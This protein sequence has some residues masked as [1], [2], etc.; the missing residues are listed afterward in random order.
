MRSLVF[1]IPGRLETPTGGYVY[2]RRMI[3]GLRGQGWTVD[4]QTLDASFPHPTPAALAHAARTLAAVARGTRVLV[5]G[6]ACSAMP[7]L[8][9]HE[10]A[11]LRIAA[12]VHLP[13]AADLTRDAETSARLAA[14]EKRALRAAA[15]VI[16]TGSTTRALIENYQIAPERMVVVE[17][18]TVRRTVA[19]RL[20]GSRV[21][22]LCVATLHPGKGHEIL[23]D[24]LAPL[25]H[26]DWQLVCA[27]SLTRHPATAD[28][29]RAAIARLGLDR[30]VSL[31]GEL[32]EP[33]LRRCYDSADVFV[34]AT[35]QETYG[36]AVAEALA[37][38][39]PIVATTTGA[40]ADMVGDDAGLLVPS[41]DTAA[42]TGALEHVIRDAALRA[43]LGDGAERARRRLPTWDQASRRMA[44]A[45]EQ[46]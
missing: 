40:I 9:E 34:L 15:L 38:G 3:E 19:P 37:H 35:L 17:P 2:D 26:L 33:A 8:I 20:G 10:A 28:R 12:L 42:L 22:L 39:L 24:A 13:L 32:D 27:G 25:T 43:R 36:M 6:L 1:L 44:E 21:L 18:G 31:L 30:H 5:D 41:G 14:A 45:L 29:V 11:R 46:L 7:D 23:L 16:V 4:V